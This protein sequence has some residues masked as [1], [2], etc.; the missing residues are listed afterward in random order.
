MKM[1]NMYLLSIFALTMQI[2]TALSMNIITTVAKGVVSSLCSV[3]ELFITSA[4]ILGTIMDQSQAR[5]IEKLTD[6]QSMPSQIVTDY[7]TSIATERGIHNPQVIIDSRCDQY[8]KDPYGSIVY[9]NPKEA[10]ELESLL[11]NNNRTVEEQKTLHRH[12]GD[13]YHEW[14]HHLRNSEHCMHVYKA[15]TGTAGAVATSASLSHLISK[16]VPAIKKNFMFHNSFKIARSGF[17]YWL[18]LK[19]AHT[20]IPYLDN[21]YRHYEELQTDKG[22]PNKKELLEPQ[23]ELYENRHANMI[24]YINKTKNAASYTDIIS[25]DPEYHAN[26]FELLAIK[27]LPTK[28]F[29]NP[30]I[31]NAT[32]YAKDDHPSDIQ[33]AN[34]VR[35]RIAKL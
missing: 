23:A 28:W 1:R 5:H 29:N 30:Y 31:M 25:P 15:V 35:D 7:I 21:M 32:L 3:S 2:N 16:Y 20:Q 34:R 9:I 24:N 10:S 13:I 8:S 14:Q 18:A 4:P 11:Q 12:T 19:L 22:I 27:T 6:T 26:R 33:R 17:T